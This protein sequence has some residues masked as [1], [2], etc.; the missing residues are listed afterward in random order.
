VI[1]R[2]LAAA[3][4]LAAIALVGCGDDDQADGWT[5]VATGD[6]YG[7]WELFAEYDDGEWTG[8]LR[9]DHDEADQCADPDTDRLVTF[10]SSDGVTYGA[11]PAGAELEFADG[12]EVRLIDD[13]F[14]VVA[15]DAEVQ[16]AG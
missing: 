14:F 2:S 7:E 16:L 8:C 13:R 5:S 15:S 11:V 1:S 4:L 6:T 3:A 9:I 10:E 12:D